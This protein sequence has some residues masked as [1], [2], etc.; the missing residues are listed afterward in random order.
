MLEVLSFQTYKANFN[1][2]QRLEEGRHRHITEWTNEN[3]S[4]NLV[5]KRINTIG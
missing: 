4:P 5:V 1:L 3:L 2:K